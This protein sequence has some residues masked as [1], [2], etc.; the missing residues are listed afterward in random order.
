MKVL[1]ALVRHRAKFNITDTEGNSPLM[2]AAMADKPGAVK[3]SQNT[4]NCEIIAVQ[5]C[6]LQCPYVLCTFIN[7][8]KFS[9]VVDMDLTSVT[10]KVAKVEGLK[11]KVDN[12]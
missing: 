5:Q 8:R 11:V 9:H 2:Y 4:V 3:V 10:V 6:N 7:Q 1:R 12:L